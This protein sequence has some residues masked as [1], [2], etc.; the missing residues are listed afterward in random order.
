MIG[1]AYTTAKTGAD[2]LNIDIGDQLSSLGNKIFPNRDKKRKYR[3]GYLNAIHDA[4]VNSSIFTNLH[5]DSWKEGKEIAEF[6]Q[7]K[8]QKGVEYINDKYSGESNLGSK[9]GGHSSGDV[10]AGFDSWISKFH[11]E[12]ES[13][14]SSE[15]GQPVS[16]ASLGNFGGIGAI[17]ILI[18]AIFAG[19][20]YV[21]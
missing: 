15:T 10:V 21:K 18:A 12:N 8:G 13:S 7:D 17:I 4:G 6:L 20:N 14:E 2:I 3:D 5:S 11:S 19:L 9:M 1:A 16:A